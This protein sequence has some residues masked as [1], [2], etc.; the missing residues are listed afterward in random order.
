VLSALAIAALALVGVVASPAPQAQALQAGTQVQLELAAAPDFAIPNGNV[1]FYASSSGTTRMI[2]NVGQ[3]LGAAWDEPVHLPY[4]TIT[5]CDDADVSQAFLLI[6]ADSSPDRD[7]SAVE[8]HYFSIFSPYMNLCTT[9]FPNRS[10]WETTYAPCASNDPTQEYRVLEDPDPA[11]FFVGWQAVVDLAVLAASDLCLTDLSSCR[12]ATATN[13][14]GWFAPDDQN[15]APS[16]GTLST[17]LLGCGAGDPPYTNDSDAPSQKTLTSSVSST[18]S[19]TATETYGSTTTVSASGGIKDVF[20]VS[21]SEG[22]TYGSSK[23]TASSQTQTSQQSVT[24]TVQPGHTLMTSWSEQVFVLDGLWKFGREIPDSAGVGFDWSIPATSSYPAAVGDDAS[25]Q[26]VSAV[27]SVTAKS[28]TAGPASTVVAKPRLTSDPATCDSASPAPASGAVGSVVWTCPGEWS[29]P[30]GEG[31]QQSF[32][33][34]WSLYPGGTA[35]PVPIP[36]QTSRSFTIQPSTSGG[37]TL[38]LRVT[39]IEEGPPSRLESQPALSDDEV[40]VARS[41]SAPE[42]PEPA[43]IVGRLQQ[44]I[45]GDPYSS[46]VLARSGG[47]AET[48]TASGLPE[49]FRFSPD[50]VLSGTPRSPFVQPITITDQASGET[51]TVTLEAV[52]PRVRF[53]ETAEIPAVVGDPLSVDLVAEEAPFSTIS[54]AD[55]TLPDGLTLSSAGVLT[56]T[57]TAAGTSRVNVVSGSGDRFSTT[58]TVRNSGSVFA[59]SLPRARVGV[60]YQAKAVATVGS[61]GLFALDASAPGESPEWIVLDPATG[62]LSGVPTEIGPVSVAVRNVLDPA[63][64]AAVLALD[65]VSGSGEAVSPV[66]GASPAVP[67]SAVPTGGAAAVTPS[68]SALADTGFTGADPLRLALLLGAAGSV[69]LLARRLAEQIAGTAGHLGRARAGHH[70]TGFDA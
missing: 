64:P 56:G 39:V 20:S 58:I 48:L 28:C 11:G 41:V 46:S 22:F 6:P 24:Q 13:P 59:S 16:G 51:S 68:A 66:P 12:V 57:P 8:D 5:D 52:E 15:F 1:S 9:V 31:Q 27:T 47:P 14:D 37:S 29:T 62:V 17:R 49:G 55:G 67:G 18:S 44:A 2:T 35:T 30:G 65:V 50:G 32:L 4:P 38:Y 34:Q 25:Y 54:L 3:C 60:P 23:V 53:V 26:Q 45:V 61:E 70:R 21:V 40:L 63:A 69:L 36:D 19:T 7:G 43:S 33:Y 42:G 10:F